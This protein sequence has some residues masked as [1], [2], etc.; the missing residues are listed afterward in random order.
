MGSNFDHLVVIQN[1]IKR[2]NKLSENN[3]S[4][5]NSNNNTN[6]NY[7]FG[8]QISKYF[9]IYLTHRGS[10]ENRHV[11]AHEG[12]I[13]NTLG[14]SRYLTTND[15][16]TIEENIASLQNIIKSGKFRNLLIP[17]S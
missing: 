3:I 5:D 10:V 13:Q 11:L 6:D 4:N 12:I 8:C 7:I 1:I 15:I 9:L 17:T 14:K 2:I 16:E